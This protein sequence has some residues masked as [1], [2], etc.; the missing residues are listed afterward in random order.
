MLSL[1]EEKGKS[2]TKTKVFSFGIT[3]G[4]DRELVIK[5]AELGK[6]THQIIGSSDMSMIK[7]AVITS[8]RR[9]GAPSL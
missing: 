2:D 4:C 1:I 5:S 9:A 6:G 8:L 3:D 7:E